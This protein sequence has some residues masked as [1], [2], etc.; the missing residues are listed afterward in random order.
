MSFT[1][2]ILRHMFL[3][4]PER[5]RYWCGRRGTNWSQLLSRQWRKTEGS[6]SSISAHTQMCWATFSQLGV[7]GN[8]SCDNSVWSRRVIWGECCHFRSVPLPYIE[9]CV[10]Q[11]GITKSVSKSDLLKGYQWVLSSKHVCVRR[12]S[13]IWKYSISE[14]DLLDLVQAFQHFEV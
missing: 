14:K 11:V 6:W 3:F 8:A 10:K 1:I 7:F 9:E 13:Y 2:S 4:F 12:I 5:T